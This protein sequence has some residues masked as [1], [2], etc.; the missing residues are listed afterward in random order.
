M[1]SFAW[2]G[3]LR[4]PVR[5]YALSF[6]KQLLATPEG[7]RSLVV[8][9]EG[10]PGRA[11]RLPPGPQPW[12]DPVYPD[13]GRAPVS[14]SRKATPVF[15]TARFRSGSTLLWNI[16]RQVK[17][18]T[19]Y[20]E[21]LNERRWFDPATRG[22]RTDPTHSGVS[23]YW[24]EY[25]GL[26]HLSRHYDERWIDHQLYMGEDFHAPALRA[27]VDALIEAAPGAAVL[28]FNR[29][30]FRV[31]WLRKQFPEARLIHLYRHPRDQWCSSL[32]R[33]R[34]VP[35][36]VGVTQFRAFDHFYLLPWAEDLSYT[37][38]L[39]NPAEAEHPYDLFYLIW[40][41]SYAFGRAYADLSVGFEQLAAEPRTEIPRLM[42]VARIRDYDLESVVKVVVP[43]ATG[44]WRAYA[45]ED[46]FVTREARCEA[47][48]AAYFRRAQTPEPVVPV[49]GAEIRSA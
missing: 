20:Y 32:V 47:L 24:R 25:E 21:P 7:R 36:D 28:Q 3:P 49:S 12:A 4:E 19:S 38:P 40:K 35:R 37:F 15:I 2:L 18:C 11:V 17:T 42:S 34:D 41:L 27:Y 29:V 23:D 43:Q 13:L 6:L 22:D 10:Q 45:D 30:D 8:A 16:F 26:T 1:P 39:L 48:L 5:R 33:P 9:L 31:A 44:K 14:H 46:W